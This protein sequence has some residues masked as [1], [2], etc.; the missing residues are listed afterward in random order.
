MFLRVLL[1]GALASGAVAQ[2]SPQV[3]L[4]NLRE[5][6]RGLTQRV[7]E[8]ALRVEQLER[9]NT[10][11]RAKSGATQ[12]SYATV[13]QLR[14][15]VADVQRTL[16]ASISSSK[17]ETLERVATQMANLAKQTNAALDSL[18]RTQPAGRVAA[19]PPPPAP[20]TPP[21]APPK[22]STSYVVQKGDTLALIAKKTG[23]KQQDIINAN[24][25]TDPSRILA[26]QTLFIPNANSGAK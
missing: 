2:T 24:K 9:E 25:L 18:A 13:A 21:E 7:G 23:A 26:G 1:A 3:E 5:D 17:N 22:D 15:A 14:E 19:A 10:E 6:V 11:L 20:A 16:E 4:A 8:L 12:K